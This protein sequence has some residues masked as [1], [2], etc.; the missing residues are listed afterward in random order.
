MPVYVLV[1][2]MGPS[3][4]V[5]FAVGDMQPSDLLGSTASVVAGE[6]IGKNE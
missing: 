5:S 1:D 4:R 3:D 6:H 2:G